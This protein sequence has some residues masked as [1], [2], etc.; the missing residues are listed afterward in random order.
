MEGKEDK[1]AD[2]IGANLAF[3]LA[4]IFILLAFLLTKDW[5]LRSA[6]LPL[7]LLSVF[8]GLTFLKVKIAMKILRVTKLI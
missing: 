4:A 6:W 7:V 8:I 2:K 1:S 3:T 5:V